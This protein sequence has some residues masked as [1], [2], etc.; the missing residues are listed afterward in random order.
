MSPSGPGEAG[1]ETAVF[2]ASPLI[3]LDRLGYA[4]SLRKLYWVVLPEAV[5]SELLARPRSP[6]GKIPHQPWV[7]HSAPAAHTL[8]RVRAEAPTVGPGETAAIA[9][10]LDLS[11]LVVL[12]DRRARRRASRAGLR[13][14]GTLGILVVIHRSGLAARSLVSDV[15]ILERAGMRISPTLRQDI[16]DRQT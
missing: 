5:A 13:I 14:T 11:A 15:A 12:D 7:Q 9:L 3:F 2:D 1:K 8:R 16:L 6:G 4:P 10:A